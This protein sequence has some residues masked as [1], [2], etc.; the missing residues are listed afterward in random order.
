MI[1]GLNSVCR[2]HHYEVRKKGFWE[3]EDVIFNMGSDN[4]IDSDLEHK[5]HTKLLAAR[6]G[7]VGTEIS[8]AIEALRKGK[9]GYEKTDTFED[10]LADTFLRL[11]DIVGGLEIDI[12]RQL[13]WKSNH[14]K[15][16]EVRHGKLF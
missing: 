6:L 8:E 11:M 10:E 14:S 3:L 16:R 2:A 15:G 1:E 12:E 13:T 4:E 5:L 7:L 9:Y